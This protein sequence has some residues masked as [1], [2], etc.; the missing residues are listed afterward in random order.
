[1][2]TVRWVAALAMLTAVSTSAGGAEPPTPNG[3]FLGIPADMLDSIQD[4]PAGPAAI[5]GRVVHEGESADVG[6]IPVVLYAQSPNGAP[7][8][9]AM[10]TDEA[11]AFAFESIPNDP[12]IVYLLGTRYAEIP[13]GVRKLLPQPRSILDRPARR[14]TPLRHI[15]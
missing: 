8:L 1:M 13:S 12:A 6:G 10:V 14:P 15:V 5:R 2:R 9:R 3:G 7:G 11:G 4:I